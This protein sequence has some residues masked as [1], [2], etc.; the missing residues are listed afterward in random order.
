MGLF[1]RRGMLWIL[2]CLALDF[3]A[4]RAGIPLRR[5]RAAEAGVR[6]R[7]E[8]P[9]ELPRPRTKG[10]V[11]LEETVKGRRTVR[12]YAGAPLSPEQLAQLLWAAQGITEERGRKRAAPSGGALYP[13]DIYV[14]VGREGVEG[15]DA[16]VYHYD[17]G[18]HA[19]SMVAEG[20]RRQA[21]ARAALGQTWMAEAP[22][23]FVIAAEYSRICIKYGDRG[24]RYAMIEAGHIGQ[25]VFLQA[26]ALGLSAGIVGAFR[27][28]DVQKVMGTPQSHEPLLIMPVGRKA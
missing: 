9:M 22:V 13:M 23:N 14:L 6:A 15:V 11:S 24:V 28:R 1:T 10:V 21:L 27:D 20:D 17:P 7:K 16:G 8:G 12:S 4:P 2:S 3:L 18:D 5:I 25:N 19:L 26:Q